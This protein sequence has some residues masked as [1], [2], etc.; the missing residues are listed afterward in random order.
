MRLLSICAALALA[1]PGTAALAQ[2]RPANPCSKGEL[3]T[4]R[5]SQ[6]KPG[7]SM[8]G[9]MQAVREHRAWYASHR[10]RH[11][12]V[13]GPVMTSKGGTLKPTDEVMTLSSGT[14]A[15]RSMRD[16][17]WAAFVAQ[18]Q[19]NSTIKSESLVCMQTGR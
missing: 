18:Y 10:I 12:L 2:S 8:K 14:Y 3:T 9:F 5:V 15:P 1:L 17:G 6:I 19:A 7:G 4:I 11:K 13:V 16:K